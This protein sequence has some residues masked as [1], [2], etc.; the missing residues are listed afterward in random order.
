MA[1]NWIRFQKGYSMTQFM[2]DYGSEEQ[3]AEALFRWRWPTGFVCPRCEHTRY[4]RIQS[5]SLYQCRGCRHQVSL[6]AGTILASTKLPLRTWFL[7]MYL[8]TQTK[9]GIRAYPVSVDRS[10]DV[11]IP[12]LVI[13]AWK[14]TA[15]PSDAVPGRRLIFT[16]SFCA[17]ASTGSATIA[18]SAAA[19]SVMP[20]RRRI[21]PRELRGG[22]AALLRS[23]QRQVSARSAEPGRRGEDTSFRGGLTASRSCP[24]PP[25]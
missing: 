12:V 5:R 22:C 9:N 14:R 16:T 24:V 10:F 20:T 19:A 4:C 13:S 25:A 1:R 15:P 3:C 11:T 21:S 2:E 6:I 8:M 17:C 18:T 23:Y 7:A